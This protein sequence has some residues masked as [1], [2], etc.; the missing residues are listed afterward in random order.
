MVAVW[1]PDWP[2]VAA[3]VAADVP[4]HLPIAVLAANRVVACSEVARADGV[5][6]GQRRRDAQALC[7]ELVLLDDDPDRDARAF[8]PVV[9]AVEE[10]SP[11]VEIV[12]PGLCAFRVRGPARYFGSEPAVAERVVDLVAAQTGV[13]T[14]VGIAEGVFAAAL[15]ARTGGIVPPGETP[16]FLAPLDLAVLASSSLTAGD[17]P[18]LVSLMRR[19]GIRTVGAFAALPAQDVLARF[20]PDGAAAHRLARGLE[21]RPLV[22]RLPPVDLSARREIDP[23]AE[24]VDTVAFVA[25]TLAEEFAERLAAHGLACTRL[26]IEAVTANGEELSRTWRHDGVLGVG[27]IADRVR[28]QLDGWLTG[29]SREDRP[30]AGVAVVRLA[31]EDV[32]EHGGAQLGLWGDTGADDERA[33]RALT[34]VQGLLGPEAVVTPVL[35][36]GR[37]PESR[38]RYVAW[39]DAREPSLPLEPPWP[40]QLPPPAPATVPHESPPVSVVGPNGEAVGV[41]GRHALTS[42]PA[43]VSLGNGPGRTVLAWAGPWPADERWWSPVQARRRAWMQVVLDGEEPSAFLLALESGSWLLAGVYD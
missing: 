18:D 1:A 8:E 12:R 14:A 4:L 17:Q 10:L 41:T 16:A 31:P 19:L 23:P 20:G 40:G 13:E 32:V 7:P 24:R 35:G 25:R 43:R 11:G 42:L 3:A 38:V 37:D 33:H 30:T 9:A 2:V 5:R 34:R 29:R 28:W 15:A 39:R 26:V 21:P 22:A 6:R 27:D 36:G